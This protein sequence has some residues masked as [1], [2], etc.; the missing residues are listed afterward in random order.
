VKNVTFNNFTQQF[1]VNF[2]TTL[3]NTFA[4]LVA[5]DLIRMRVLLTTLGPSPLNISSDYAYI[6]PYTDYVS[7]GNL[8][9]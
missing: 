3:T 1:T 7:S 4:A 8:I 9:Y 2:G 6:V 5:G